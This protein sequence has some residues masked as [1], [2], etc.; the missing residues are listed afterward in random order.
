LHTPCE[1]KSTSD[2]LFLWIAGS[3]GMENKS[4]GKYQVRFWGW[5]S[6]IYM[7]VQ[8]EQV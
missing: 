6:D 5:L 3:R 2:G 7:V 1:E 4:I 8:G